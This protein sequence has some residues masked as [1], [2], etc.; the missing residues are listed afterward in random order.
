M[1]RAV[2]LSF[3]N[4]GK[5]I[6][7]GDLIKSLRSLRDPCAKQSQRA[8]HLFSLMKFQQLSELYASARDVL[9]VTQLMGT[10]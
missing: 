5:I 9:R 3:T 4:F 7:R 10:P 1:P 6:S 8:L 2:T